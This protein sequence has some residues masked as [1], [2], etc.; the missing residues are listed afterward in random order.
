VFA[1]RF[2]AASTETGSSPITKMRLDNAI[3]GVIASNAAGVCM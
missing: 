3:V 2:I 1:L